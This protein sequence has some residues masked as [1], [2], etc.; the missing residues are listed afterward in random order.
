MAEHEP[1][2][3]VLG[4]LVGGAGGE[5]VAGAERLDQRGGVQGAGHGVGV[6]VAEVDGDGAAVRE[7][8]EAGL[9]GGERLVPADLAPEL[10]L[11]DQRLAQPVGV[12]VEPAEAGSLRADE[13]LAE[14]IV[15][16]APDT[17]DVPA[18]VEGEGQAADGLAQGTGPVDGRRH[19]DS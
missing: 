10:A 19:H 13:P 14:R 6:G 7:A 1:A 18:V 12:L 5:D 15:L 8:V 11:P 16:V 17:G 9:H 3:H 4:H 2:G